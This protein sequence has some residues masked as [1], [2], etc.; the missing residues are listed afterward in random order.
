MNRNEIITLYY[1]DKG[2]NDAIA[3]ICPK[4]LRDDLKQHIFLILSE[5]TEGEI[6]A[7]HYRQQ[8]RFFIVRIIINSIR[9]NGRSDFAKLFRSHEE[10]TDEPE[11]INFN[12]IE[13]LEA[14][15]QRET[16]EKKIEE[17][18][19]EIENLHPY[20]RILL[21]AYAEKGSY[22]KAAAAT[23][24]NTMTVFDAVKKAKQEIKEK[25]K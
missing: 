22:R 25:I 17:C 4:H 12:P 21:K 7:M 20:Y 15:A 8:I 1:N 6:V 11:E 18:I 9:G 3:N 24:F 2:V 23:E 14:F 19:K 5:K 13:Y 16:D 10:L